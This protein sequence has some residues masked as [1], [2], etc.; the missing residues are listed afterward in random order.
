MTNRIVHHTASDLTI[1]VLARGDERY[2]LMYRE[3][4]RG[5]AMRQA[6]RWASNQDLSFTWWDCARMSKE[7]TEASRT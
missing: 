4:N 2:I 5:D 6:G 7:I 3:A 1:I